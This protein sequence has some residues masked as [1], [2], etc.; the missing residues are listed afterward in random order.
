MKHFDPF[1]LG[2]F[3]INWQAFGRMV[4]ETRNANGMSLREAERLL[5]ISAATLSRAE[6]G[7]SVEPDHFFTLLQFVGVTPN[8]PEKILE[9]GTPLGT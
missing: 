8:L 1:P 9:V 2:H 7:Y 4:F 5:D 3:K 6:R